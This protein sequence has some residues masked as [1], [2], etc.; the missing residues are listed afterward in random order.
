MKQVDAVE[1][2]KGAVIWVA[3]CFIIPLTCHEGTTHTHTHT[4][5]HMYA[6]THTHSYTQRRKEQRN[7][8]GR[9]K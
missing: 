7:S 2:E 5:T 1:V 6:R 9:K 8:K 3:V 4:N